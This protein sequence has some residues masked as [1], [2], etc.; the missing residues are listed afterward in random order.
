MHL[1][2]HLPAKGFTI[3]HGCHDRADARQLPCL[4]SPSPLL[5]LLSLQRFARPATRFAPLDRRATAAL[6][7]R[8]QTRGTCRLQ[9]LLRR[10]GL[11]I[12]FHRFRLQ[13]EATRHLGLPPSRIAYAPSCILGPRLRTA[14][15]EHH[16]NSPSRR[17]LVAPFQLPL[18]K[19]LH[20]L[21]ARLDPLFPDTLAQPL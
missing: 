18:A 21:V 16:R 20:L 9:K 4:S 19:L 5:L 10:F 13:R 3:L 15:V 2:R 14:A 6:D 17:L 12:H 7:F 11:R 1:C 8:C